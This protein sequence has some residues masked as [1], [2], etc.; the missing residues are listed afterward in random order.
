MTNVARGQVQGPRS[1]AARL[2]GV[3]G[4]R[5]DQRGRRGP[6]G[7]AALPVAPGPEVH[8]AVRR[9]D[10]HL[11]GN[12]RLEDLVGARVGGAQV[13]PEQGLPREGD[14]RGGDEGDVARL[15]RHRP[16]IRGQLH[17]DP[18]PGVAAVVEP[19]V[20][21]RQVAAHRDPLPGRLQVRLGAHRVLVVAQL[22][23]HPRQQLHHGHAEVRLVGFLPG[24]HDQGQPVRQQLPEAGE[25]LGQVGQVRLDQGLG[26][27]GLRGGA[28][29]PAGAAGHEREV[30]AGVARI[31]PGQRDVGGAALRVRLDQAQPVARGVARLAHGD[32]DAV[33]DVGIVVGAQ[34]DVHRG[35][36]GHLL[37]AG[38]RDVAGAQA[39]RGLGQE[40]DRQHEVIVADLDVV[41]AVLARAADELPAHLVAADQ[42]VLGGH[43]RPPWVNV[44]CWAEP[45]AS[46]T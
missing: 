8:L 44:A 4:P 17:A 11:T 32:L 29:E 6:G 40:A 46:T 15:E 45:V 38:D 18:G 41:Q 36:P 5:V 7:Q 39:G 30:D 23:T 3:A 28:V 16:G 34:L 22:V 42:A 2:R 20:D 31:E 25:V 21:Q 13:G 12:E 9:V 24:R 1:L 10:H 35:D 19:V 37:A 26:R 14:V 27:A 33:V 43:A